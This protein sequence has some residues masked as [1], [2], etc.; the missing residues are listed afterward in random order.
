MKSIIAYRDDVPPLNDYPRQ[1]VSPRTSSACCH[2]QMVQ[3]G[4]HALDAQWRFYYQRCLVCGFTVRRFYAPSLLA[5][6]EVGRELRVALADM[7]LGAGPRK[8]RT[9]A[10]LAADRAAARRGPLRRGG[11]TRG[12]VRSA[13]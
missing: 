10:Q 6:F 3:L 12:W 5:L 11:Q 2:S 9:R 4:Q 13:A 1:I 7:N 8:R